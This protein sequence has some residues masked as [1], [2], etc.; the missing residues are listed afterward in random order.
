MSHPNSSLGVG[1]VLLP[2]PE[3]TRPLIITQQWPPYWCLQPAGQLMAAWVCVA[4]DGNSSALPVGWT[5][6]TITAQWIFS[7][8]H[9]QTAHAGEPL[10]FQASAPYLKKSWHGLWRHEE[11]LAPWDSVTCYF[12]CFPAH[13]YL[14]NARS[15]S[16]QSNGV[17]D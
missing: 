8:C 4:A 16:R 10:Q 7:L 5:L 3:W 14:S 1:V 6:G 13:E 11:G 12:C 15:A 9:F 2:G 17:G